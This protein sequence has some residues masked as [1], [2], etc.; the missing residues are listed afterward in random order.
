MGRDK[1]CRISLQGGTCSHHSCCRACQQ[2][3]AEGV[4]WAG[5]TALSFHWVLAP[6]WAEVTGQ[7]LWA[8]PLGQTCHWGAQSFA[9]VTVS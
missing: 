7:K 2:S 4:G 5:Q 1:G 6:G 3:A 9:E 8:L